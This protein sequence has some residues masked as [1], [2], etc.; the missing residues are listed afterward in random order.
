MV[1]CVGLTAKP[2]TPR[3]AELPLLPTGRSQQLTL[4]IVELGIPVR[5]GPY[6][7]GHAPECRPH[8]PSEGSTLIDRLKKLVL[9]AVE[10]SDDGTLGP[11]TRDRV[12]LRRQM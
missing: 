6:P 12:V 4:G 3:L 2:I 5:V 1:C 11:P 7:F 8:R 10:V 9:G